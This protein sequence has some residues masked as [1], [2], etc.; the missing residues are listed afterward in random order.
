MFFGPDIWAKEGEIVEHDLEAH[1]EDL[2]TKKL[3]SDEEQAIE[4][5]TAAT[6]TDLD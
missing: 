2:E 4:V 3:W 1:D 5:E 6:W